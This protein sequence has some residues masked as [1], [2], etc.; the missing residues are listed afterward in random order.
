MK[1]QI[2]KR[3]TLWRLLAFA[4]EKRFQ[5]F[6]G[7]LGVA[8]ITT[9]ERM[10]IAYIIKVFVDSLAFKDLPLLWKTLGI[11]ILFYI[12]FV[13]LAPFILYTWR[14]AVFQATTNLRQAVFEHLQRL[15]LSYHEMRHSG[16]AI[17][18]LTNDVTAAE[19]AYQQDLMTLVQSTLM[20]LS[21]VVFM[22]VLE[23]KL[24]LLIFLSG[25]LPLIINTLFAKP[26][27]KV[28]DDVQSSLGSMTERFSDLLAG[29]QVVRTFSLGDW[30]LSRFKKANGDVLVYSLKR[31]R[32]NANLAA[33][34]GFSSLIGVIPYTVGAF[35][36]MYGQT[37]LGVL[38]GLIQL[39]NQI[40][41]FVY[42]L[43][44]TITRIQAS[45]AAADRIFVMLDTAP[46]PEQYPKPEGKRQLPS[47]QNSLLE[48]KQIRFGYNAEQEILKGLSFSVRQGQV[49][50]FVGPSGGGKSTIF[51][52]LLGCYPL[53][54][55]EA[56]VSDRPVYDYKLSELRQL[57]AYVPQDAYLYSGTILD[58]IRYG[59]PTATDEEVVAAANDAY[60][61]GFISEFPEGYHTQVGERGARLS[62][63]QRQRIA[64]AR[65]LLKD[66]PILLLDEATSSLDS[67]SEEVVQRALIRLMQGRTTL[68]IAHRISTIEN[69]DIIY[70]IDDGKVVEQ[71]QHDELLA[72]NGLFKNLHDLQFK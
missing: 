67:D 3:Q 43:G 27:R 7:M 59:R 50:A 51:R 64:I 62:G 45:L 26:L 22:L 20:G 52:L 33:A 39:S 71:G 38:I 16:D 6:S 17:S 2:I 28:G 57:F 47:S 29:F 41:Y 25:V 4:G 21:A 70:V 34:N 5:L 68:A 53:R 56:F 58:N 72:Q 19:A 65:A 44:G 24:A 18:I 8:V 55:G 42:S 61:H 11:W 49:A 54:Q 32:I 12:G 35:L 9:T 37:T 1:K 15:P 10:F 46:E 63:G 48:F 13:A 23:W 14:A 60:A 30:I 36:V 40:N 69:A 66:A 31:V